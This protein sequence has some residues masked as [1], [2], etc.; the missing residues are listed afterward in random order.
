VTETRTR[1][2]RARRVDRSRQ[3]AAYP[4]PEQNTAKPDWRHAGLPAMPAE[5]VRARNILDL[6]AVVFKLAGFAAPLAAVISKGNKLKP[7]E[8]S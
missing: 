1:Q 5:K 7:S 2:L 4:P 6:H 3:I 8:L